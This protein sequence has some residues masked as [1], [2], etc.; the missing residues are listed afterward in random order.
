MDDF[1]KIAIAL[2]PLLAAGLNT[3]H[4][5]TPLEGRWAQACEARA[6][7]GEEFVGS[8]ARY[9]ENY[10]ADGDCHEP[11]LSFEIAGPFSFSE[12]SP[13][14]GNID[15]VFETVFAIAKDDR[16]TEQFNRTR[17]CGWSD[18]KT[19]EPRDVTSLACDFFGTGA[20]LRSPAR[21]EIRYGIWKIDGDRLLFG[22]LEPGGDGLSPETRPHRLNP[23]YFGRK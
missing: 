8:Q 19:D 13:L 4:S 1:V 6:Y 23:K 15:F 17:T 18:W 12:R 16:M 3:R 11:L 9:T 5:P 10:F 2:F 21:G 20:P 7:R 14:E 22:T